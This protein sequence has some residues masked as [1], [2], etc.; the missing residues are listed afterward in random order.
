MKQFAH[1]VSAPINKHF[2]WY[3]YDVLALALVGPF[4]CG[5]AECVYIDCGRQFDYRS[6]TTE[7]ITNDVGEFDLQVRVKSLK[8]E[9]LW[10]PRECFFELAR[11]KIAKVSRKQTKTQNYLLLFSSLDSYRQL[12]KG[13]RL[14]CPTALGSGRRREP[15]NFS[16]AFTFSLIGSR[17]SKEPEPNTMIIY[18]PA[19]R[20]WTC[21]QCCF[22]H[23]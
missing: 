20:P 9:R 8:F 4:P 15:E 6:V 14:P 21:P 22:L 18:G 10:N 7:Y 5:V 11:I 16:W 1:V 23:S 2:V 12:G 17:P 3:I 13:Y 19:A